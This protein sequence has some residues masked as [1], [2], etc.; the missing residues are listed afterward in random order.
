MMNENYR[1]YYWHT[2]DN[3]A[4]LYSCVSTENIS[5]VFRIS[6]MLSEPVQPEILYQAL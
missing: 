5:N 3:A 6:A 1:E 4:K 2:L